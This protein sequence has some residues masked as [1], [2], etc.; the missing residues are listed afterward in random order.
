[1]LAYAHIAL[2]WI[3]P[4]FFVL[5]IVVTVH[6]F[7]H[8]IAARLCGV[9]VDQFSIG[10]GRALLKRQDRQG[11]E[12]RLGWIPLG[13]YVRFAG[14]ENA[15]SVPD[16]ED[17]DELRKAIVAHE[18][19]GA[20]KRYYAFKPIW[21]RAIIAAAGPFANFGLSIGLLAVLFLIFG[22]QV[23]PAKITAVLPNSP[24]AAGGF[25][26]G[27][28]VVK[29]AGRT[30]E[31][32]PD[33]TEVVVFRTG[34]AIPFQVMRGGKIVDLVATPRSAVISDGFGGHQEGGQ[35][36]LESRPTAADVVHKRF[37]PVEALGRGVSATWDVFDTTLFYLQRVVQGQVSAN[38]L[39]GPLGVAQM[40]HDVAK[41]GAEQA[42]SQTVQAQIVGSLMALLYMVAFYSVGIGFANLLP[43]PVLDGGHLLFYAYE[44]VARRPVGAR[45][46]AVSYRVGLAL[47]LGLMLFATTNDL[48]RS[49]VFHFLGGP[50]S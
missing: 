43:I 16:S 17:L 44:A 46:Q 21:Q 48:Q 6:E 20:L 4:F 22:E 36:G 35:L 31:S 12:W 29:A 38:Q 49:G 40:S 50:F 9:A 30:I 10:F 39:H 18:G 5:T 37:G 13:G 25:M 34:I 7:G 27:D 33:L 26:P 23:V 24:A 14:D 42:H 19:V 3:L 47:V 2:T 8:F 41:I 15:A 11:T 32:F 45:V 28:T 1:M